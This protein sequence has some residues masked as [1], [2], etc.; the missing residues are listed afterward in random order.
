MV[1]ALGLVLLI[2]AIAY[3]YVE[4]GR[5]RGQ[6]DMKRTELT[7]VKAELARATDELKAKQQSL[8]KITPAALSGL[9]YKNPYA[10]VPSQ[11]V[12][13]SVDAKQTAERLAADP[14]QQSRRRTITLQ[15]YEKKLDDEVNMRVVLSA[16]A[17]AGFMLQ[18]KQAQVPDTPTNAIFVGPDV[19]RDDIKLVA[20]T[21][22]GA[23][24]KLRT[25]QPLLSA[26]SR[27]KLIQI[28]ADRAYRDAPPL[29]AK[30]VIQAS[31]FAR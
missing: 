19:E 26:V 15:Y 1:S 20:L 11:E 28:G 29:T 6:I 10:A 21:L 18:R 13:D 7:R 17:D 31:S 2:G 27:P 3:S 25:I 16:L 14:A 12:A 9:G 4:L 23:G 30:H 8:E 5:I 22:I 24:I